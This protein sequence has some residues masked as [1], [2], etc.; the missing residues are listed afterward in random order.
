MTEM[1]KEIKDRDT[2]RLQVLKHLTK[3]LHA[4]GH[5]NINL[6][7]LADEDVV[8]V[9]WSPVYGTQ[10]NIAADSLVAMISDVMREIMRHI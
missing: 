6:A 9:H 8:V 4:A 1:E 7:L 2:K 5:T 3:T 10:V